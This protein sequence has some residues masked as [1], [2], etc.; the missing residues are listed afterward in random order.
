M[1][2]EVDQVRHLLR[3]N[4]FVHNILLQINACGNA[5]IL[6]STI[7]E[8]GNDFHMSPL[9]GYSEKDEEVV[10]YFCSCSTADTGDCQFDT[11]YFR[12][13]LTK[14]L[15]GFSMKQEHR[16]QYRPHSR[17]SLS[18]QSWEGFETPQKAASLYVQPIAKQMLCLGYGREDDP[19]LPTKCILCPGPRGMGDIQIFGSCTVEMSCLTSALLY[20]NLFGQKNFCLG[21]TPRLLNAT[22]SE[23]TVTTKTGNNTCTLILYKF[24]PVDV[25]NY[26][27]WK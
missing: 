23:K 5:E 6:K 22:C 16:P 9:G 21:E 26:M 7:Y 18:W 13:I 19:E 8:D 14:E 3:C 24:Y 20:L 10:E 1:K 11:D 25:V 12:G 15:Y 17:E 2:R 27:L 4:S